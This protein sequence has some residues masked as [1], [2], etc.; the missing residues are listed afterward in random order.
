MGTFVAYIIRAA[1]CLALLY[2]P[3]AL[4]MRKET[5]FR[6]NRAVLLAMTVLS[7]LLPLCPASCTS[8][9]QTEIAGDADDEPGIEIGI[10]QMLNA[11]LAAESDE[12]SRH[13][14][15]LVLICIY[16]TGAAVCLAHKTVEYV[17]MRRF[18]R[19][20]NLWTESSYADGITIHCKP[21]Q[22][23]PF[24]WMRDIVISEQDADNSEILL[25]EIAHIQRGHSW[26]TL[27]ILLVEVLQWF[28]PCIWLLDKALCEVHEFEADSTVLK[29][30]IEKKEYQLLL[31]NRTVG[32]GTYA[33]ANGLNHSLLKKRITMM[34]KEQSNRWSR[35]RILYVLPVSLIAVAALATPGSP[36]K[37]LREYRKSYEQQLPDS[38]VN[39][40]F[41]VVEQLPEFPGGMVG[42]MEYL[43]RN[44]KYPASAKENNIQGRTLIQFIVSEDGSITDPEVIKSLEPE[45]DKEALRVIS[46]M[47]RWT[48]GMQRGEAVSVRYTVPVMFRLRDD[49]VQQAQEEIITVQALPAEVRSEIRKEVQECLESM[50]KELRAR[51][52]DLRYIADFEDKVIVELGT[53]M[54]RLTGQYSQYEKSA[55]QGRIALT[56]GEVIRELGMSPELLHFGDLPPTRED[57][58]N[59][60]TSKSQEK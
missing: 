55:V 25:H 37:E 8:Q 18:I 2:L 31:L 49:D 39:E 40:V 47:P 26:D 13:T 3:Y 27:F 53:L 58:I 48:P 22:V 33:L 11:V 44:I 38:V 60:V 43:R 20:G 30:G 24:C 15:P 32:S 36:E 17:R 29:N 57:A 19:K 28:N 50:Q 9:P 12:A 4:L 14:W 52:G 23:S 51:L 5:Y 34:S 46:D 16:F 7:F 10:P 1:I 21:E 45:C 42:L 59:Y 54:E 35:L 41:E 6:L 56:A